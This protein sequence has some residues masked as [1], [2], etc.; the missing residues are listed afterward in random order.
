MGCELTSPLPGAGAVSVSW[1]GSRYCVQSLLK[2]EGRRTETETGMIYHRHMT[3]LQAVKARTA[4]E[5]V[6]AQQKR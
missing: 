6:K 2:E 3:N 1:F 4:S 5:G